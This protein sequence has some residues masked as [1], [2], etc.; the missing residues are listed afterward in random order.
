M[1]VLL[2]YPCLGTN[3][4][5]FPG[6]G[7]GGVGG[8]GRVSLSSH[9]VPSA[10]HF[11]HTTPNKADGI[12]VISVGHT[13]AA[14]AT[15][16]VTFLAHTAVGDRLG[17]RPAVRLKGLCF[18]LVPQVSRGGPGCPTARGAS[19]RPAPWPSVHSSSFPTPSK[20]TDSRNLL[21]R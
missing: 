13:R 19:S 12:S 20:S 5:E 18:S 3:E 6:S 7:A 11:L 15:R 16:G 8:R 21:N 14:V 4:R 2:Q 17:L 9:H 1:A 10:C